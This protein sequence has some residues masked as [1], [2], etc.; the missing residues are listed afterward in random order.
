[1]LVLE[2]AGRNMQ[3]DANHDSVTGLAN[4]R[5]LLAAID[6]QVRHEPEWMALVLIDLDFFKRINDSWGHEAGDELLRETGRRLQALL[7]LR[8]RSTGWE[9]TNL[10]C[11]YAA[12]RLPAPSWPGRP[13]PC[14]LLGE[15]YELQH[16]TV[17]LSASA[18]ISVFPSMPT[19][20]VTC[21]GWPMPPCTTPNGKGGTVMCFL[22]VP[23][24]R[25]PTKPCWSIPPCAR[26]FRATN[27]GCSTSRWSTPTTDTW[28]RSRRSLR[29][30]QHPE[31]GAISPARFISVAEESGYIAVLGDWVLGEACRRAHLAGCRCPCRWPSTS[32]REILEP[33]FIKRLQGHLLASGLPPQWL[34]LELTERALYDGNGAAETVGRPA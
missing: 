2:P 32:A 15:P 10:P 13:R 17:M 16:G 18:G 29:W 1:M 28:A 11:W 25:R 4:C 22:T 21:C 24:R 27:C 6:G 30:K 12:G 8:I 14:W 33:N 5:P 26:L 20:P 31:Y 9:E 19:M 3:Y 7:T 23:W 34:E